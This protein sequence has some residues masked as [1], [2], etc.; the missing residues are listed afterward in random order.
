MTS[1][2]ITKDDGDESDL[3]TLGGGEFV[4]ACDVGRDLRD[5]HERARRAAAYAD[6]FDLPEALARLKEVRKKI[7]DRHAGDVIVRKLVK[8]RP[9]LPPGSI[10]MG[11]LRRRAAVN[12][13]RHALPPLRKSTFSASASATSGLTSY[14]LG[15]DLKKLPKEMRREG[16]RIA[17]QLRDASDDEEL[18]AAH[19]AMLEFKQN[20][21]I[22]AAFRSNGPANL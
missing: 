22:V 13:I 4:H 7:R 11:E 15:V 12:E 3:I 8:R 21:A 20:A 18:V 1:Y 6:R 19:S 14:D 17:V 16:K 10:G 9:T 5:E 2:S